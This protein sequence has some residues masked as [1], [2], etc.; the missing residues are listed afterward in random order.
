MSVL[1]WIGILVLIAGFILVGIEMVVPGFGLPG[2]SGIICLVIGVLMTAK[3]LEA[4]IVMVIVIIVLL[5]IMLAVIMTLLGSKKIKAPIVLNDDVKGEH[6]FLNANDLEYLVGKTGVAVTDLHPGGK[7][8]F[9]G[10]DFDIISEG[11]YIKKGQSI[12]ISRIKDNKLMVID[13]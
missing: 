5:G 8:S 3:T 7:G 6:G 9:E 2:I 11:K 1:E 4:G 12:K 13:E 10:I